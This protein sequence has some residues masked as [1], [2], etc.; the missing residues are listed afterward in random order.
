MLDYSLTRQVLLARTETSFLPDR[1]PRFAAARTVGNDFDGLQVISEYGQ[2]RGCYSIQEPFPDLEDYLLGKWD[3]A[4]RKY[5]GMRTDRFLTLL[6]VHYL[7][8]SPGWLEEIPGRDYEQILR[9]FQRLVVPGL[10]VGRVDAFA[11]GRVKANTLLKIVEGY[12]EF[13]V[14]TQ[15]R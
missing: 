13:R 14:F 15:I 11:A 7:G 10:M 1:D 9:A 8:E 3:I 2:L 4:R 5:N 12:E 6:A